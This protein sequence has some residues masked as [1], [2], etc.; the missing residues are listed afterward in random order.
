ME[1]KAFG[2]VTAVTMG[3]TLA[4][5]AL[6]L[7][8]V[9]LTGLYPAI[10]VLLFIA[11]IPVVSRIYAKKNTGKSKNVFTAIM[12]INLFLIPVVLWMSFVILVDRV[13]PNC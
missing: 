10:W 13:F 1:L 3:I 2:V 12:I 9:Y 4:V 8:G 11:I 7:F 5:L 6:G